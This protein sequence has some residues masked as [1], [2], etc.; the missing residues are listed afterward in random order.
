M[1]YC[2]GYTKPPTL[3]Q[4][5]KTSVSLEESNDNKKQKIR[6]KKTRTNLSEQLKHQPLPSLGFINLMCSL[7]DKPALFLYYLLM[8]VWMDTEALSCYLLKVYTLTT[9][10]YEYQEYTL[11]GVLLKKTWKHTSAF[12]HIFKFSDRNTCIILPNQ[13][14]MCQDWSK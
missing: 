3:G 8:P 12:T 5:I 2:E 13:T 6:K 9:K 14:K 7:L 1:E 4:A 11:K 10:Y